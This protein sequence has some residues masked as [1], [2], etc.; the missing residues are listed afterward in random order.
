M[1]SHFKTP[2]PSSVAAA[3]ASTLALC[4]TSAF[5]SVSIVK[6]VVG[7]ALFTPPVFADTAAASSPASTVA[8]VYAGATVCFDLNGNGACDPGEPSTTTSSTGA[9][10]LSSPTLAPL[11]A[12]I[13]TSATNNGQAITS[14]N[15]FRANVAQ[16]QA[17]TR[18]PLLAATVNLTPLSTEVALAIENQGLTYTQAVDDLAQRIDVSSADVLLPPTQVTDTTEL[19]AIL[20]ESVIAQGRLQLA[21]KFVDRGDT[22]GELRGNFDCPSVASFDPTNADGCTGTDQTPVATI[23]QAEEW[24]Y[25]LEGMPQYDYVFVIIE[26]N[27]S[28]STVMNT[29]TLPFM[30]NFLKTGNLLYNYFSTGDPS[31]PNYLAL[32]G[33]DDWGQASDEGLPYPAVTGVRGNL[34]NSLD[35]AGLSWHVYE[36]SLW[37]SPAGTQANVGASSWNAANGGLWFDNPSESSIVGVDG[38]TYGSSLRAMKH[39]P[40][41]WYADAAAQPDFV[42]N[43]RSVS[44][45]YGT[46]DVNGNAI[47]YSYPSNAGSGTT[48]ITSAGDWDSAL[49]AYATKNGITSWW[50]GNTQPWT[51]DQ[52]TQDLQAGNVANYNFIVPDQDDDMHND[53]LSPR[54]DYWAENIIKKIESSSIWNDPTKRVAIV[55]TFDEG[56]SA[57]TSCC[58]WNA[59]RSGDSAAQ[60]VTFSANGAVV[61][62]VSA[63]PPFTEAYQGKSGTTTTT[64]TSPAYST[65]NHGHGVTIFGLYSNQMALGNVPGGLYDTDYYSHFS[66]VRTLQDIFGLADPG[67]PGT[68]VNRSK[69]TENFINQNATVLPEFAG[70]SNPHFDAVRAMNHVYQFPAGV[71]RV[72]SL[73]AVTPPTTTGPDPNQTNLWQTQ[74]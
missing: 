65:G 33:A 67:L 53:G 49:Q 44:G 5:A 70:S 72:V 59:Q 61:S 43:S 74:Q 64:F 16:I 50:T 58:G 1:Q 63:L 69:Y 71:T 66:F 35:A 54:S 3:V 25:N 29:T 27:E 56:E 18:S 22:I 10:Q 39:N 28:Q 4:S 41:V 32:G 30:N 15:V 40:A 12:Q 37:P 62:S 45:A 60:L 6:G 13:S 19:P 20:K 31:E 55:L 17:A 14:R 47:A 24:A 48:A 26:E 23:P 38:A 7:G 21:A 52:F 73:G 51:Q 57:T 68:Y 46:A 11:V 36:G 42:L 8:S 2:R 34:W 9:F